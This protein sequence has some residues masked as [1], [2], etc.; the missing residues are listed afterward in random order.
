MQQE[1]AAYQNKKIADK[2]AAAKKSIAE[3]PADKLIPPGGSGKKYTPNLEAVLWLTDAFSDIGENPAFSFN[4]EKEVLQTIGSLVNYRIRHRLPGVTG[5]AILVAEQGG[6]TIMITLAKFLSEPEV[7]DLLGQYLV[8]LCTAAGPGLGKYLDPK[9]DVKDL[10]MIGVSTGKINI[11]SN[12]ATT[13]A[14]SP[15]KNDNGTWN[16]RLIITSK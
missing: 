1:Q 9:P 15:V 5:E 3:L 12:R 13:P 11:S 7:R 14:L 10:H 16:L 8:N 6:A 4:P 2:L